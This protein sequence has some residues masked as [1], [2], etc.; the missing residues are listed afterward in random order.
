MS[1][2]VFAEGGFFMWLVLLAGLGT[3]AA[4][5]LQL[6]MLRRINLIP[7]INW[8]ITGT[9]FLGALGMTLGL[10]QAFEPIGGASP[11]ERSV[12][13]SKGIA[14]SMYPLTLALQLC[15]FLALLAAATVTLKVNLKDKED[16]EPP[17]GANPP[18]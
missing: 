4:C 16:P 13:L 10:I 2:K 18:R 15:V 3:T 12:L 1:L 6:A 5:V 9:F 11:E 17:R 8:G 14:V 7:V